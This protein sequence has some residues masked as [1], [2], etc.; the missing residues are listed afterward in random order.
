MDLRTVVIAMSATLSFGI[1]CTEATDSNPPVTPPQMQPATEGLVVVSEASWQFIEVERVTARQNAAVLRAPA[2]VDF[3]DGAVSKLG[4][5]LA[6]RVEEV[7]VRTGDRV[8]PGDPLVTL[9]CPEAASSR[10][11]LATARAAHREA[12]AALARHKRMMEQGVGTQREQ[13]EAAR[14]LAETEAELARAQATVRFVG[15]SRGSTVVLRSPIA[16]TVVSRNATVGAAVEPGGEALLEVGDP[17]E[18]WVVANVFD[19]DLHLVREGM[20]AQ[21]ELPALA[22]P[23]TGRVVSLGAVVEGSARSAQVRIALDQRDGLL[24]PGMFGRVRI[25]SPDEALAIP[26]SAVLIKGQDTIVYIQAKP[27]TFIRRRVVVGHPVEG[28]VLVRSGVLSGDPVVVRGA[29]LLDGAA[30]QLL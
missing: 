18:L 2:R 15:K 27:G 28:M 30:D 7:H 24:R 5:P 20:G 12:D 11:A 25:E 23:L 6:G 16:G 9:D 1:G 14:R 22:G 10:A 26:T 29:L 3:R 21:I 17:S 13:L 8:E 4:P 19:R